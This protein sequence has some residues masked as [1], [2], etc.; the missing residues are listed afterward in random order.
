MDFFARQEAAR[1]TTA[2]LLVYFALTVLLLFAAVNAV[3]YATALLVGKADGGSLWWWH[4][5][6]PQALLGTLLLVL[7][8]SLLEW[9]RIL[10]GGGAIAEMMGATP[11]DFA[12]RDAAERR[13]LNVVEEMAIASGLPVPAVHVMHREPGINAFVAGLTPQRAVLV[14]TRG[15]LEHLRREELQGMVAHEFSH[16]L[17]GDMRLNMHLLAVLSGMLA[18]GQLGGFLMRS[19]T[20]GYDGRRERNALPWVWLFGLAVWLA[21]YAGLFM[22]RLIKAAVAREREWL[23]DASAVQFTRNP[24]GLAGALYRIREHGSSLRTLHAEELS[25]LCFGE[26]VALSRFLASH[27][28]LDERIEAICPGYLL[29][30]PRLVQEASALSGECPETVAGF[31]GAVAASATKPAADREQ[32]SLEAPIP[33]TGRVEDSRHVMTRVGECNAEDLQSSAWLHRQLPVELTRALQS[34]TGARAALYALIARFQPMS[35]A[36]VEAFL[37]GRVALARWVNQ[38]GGHL[39]AMDPV[40]ALPVVELCLPRLEQLDTADATDLLAD[41]RRFALHNRHLSVF[42]FALLKR[43][44]QQIRP[45]PAVLQRHPLEDRAQPV[46]VLVHALLVHGSHDPDALPEHYRRLM[47]THWADPPPLPALGADPLATLDR[48]LRPLRALD[49]GG[50]RKLLALCARTVES[51]GVLHIREYELL[52]VIAGLLA[53]P[54]PLLQGVNQA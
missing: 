41:L 12:T 27:P 11:V 31:A 40:L 39:E 2:R 43:V 8:G 7:G 30:L 20:G 1:R 24:E 53:C 6:T 18:V 16:I 50:Q 28:P 35:A 15:A 51:D 13:L 23:A 9:L 32:Q 22:G 14:V 5:W 17:H 44:E 21:G 42:E 49:A 33:W 37:S 45:L 54:L 52:R 46:A 4:Y 48:A 26:T 38:I 47:R 3:L 25:H 29:R 10:E 36:E 19:P 34:S